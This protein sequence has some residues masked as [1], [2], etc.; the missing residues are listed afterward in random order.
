MSGET[1]RRALSY[2]SEEISSS[3]NRIHNRVVLTVARPAS[4]II[5][6]AIISTS[7]R[8]KILIKFK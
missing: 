7:P 6:I 4:I 5:L 1:Q 3:G 2:Q 8:I